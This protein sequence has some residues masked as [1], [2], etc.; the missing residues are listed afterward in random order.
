MG[1]AKRMKRKLHI[2]D[3]YSNVQ[4]QS[5]HQPVQGLLSDISVS[6]ETLNNQ[7]LLDMDQMSI[8]TSKTS[9]NNILKKKEKRKARH[10]A[11]YVA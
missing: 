6:A 1:K 5:S 2:N 11:W 9:S 8:A 3:T 4:Q 7:R 10:D